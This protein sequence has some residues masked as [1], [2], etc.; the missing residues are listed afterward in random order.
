MASGGSD[1]DFGPAMYATD[2][3]IWDD[4]PKKCFQ[5][6]SMPVGIVSWQSVIDSYDGWVNIAHFD[7][8]LL[9][10]WLHDGH[11]YANNDKIA[12]R[13]EA[14]T[15]KVILSNKT[16]KWATLLFTI[17]GWEYVF[18][19]L[20]HRSA[21]MLIRMLF[22]NVHVC[23]YGRLMYLRVKWIWKQY[24][25]KY[26]IYHVSWKMQILKASHQYFAK[27]TN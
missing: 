8:L 15:Q 23:R 14:S 11:Y 26:Y 25:L 3:F 17:N 2:C 22:Y 7:K 9:S 20:G 19:T 18:P 4:S 6:P 24:M 13:R 1:N 10:Q 21:G 12:T 5:M 27:Q 16:S